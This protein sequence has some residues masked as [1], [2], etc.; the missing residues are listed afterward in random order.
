[1]MQYA[2]CRKQ[3]KIFTIQ[4]IVCS[5]HRAVCSEKIFRCSEQYALYHGLDSFTEVTFL[6]VDHAQMSTFVIEVCLSVQL[7]TSLLRLIENTDCG[8]MSVSHTPNQALLRTLVML[9]SGL[10]PSFNITQC[11]QLG[12]VWGMGQ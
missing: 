3:Y 10:R 8:I 2:L 5:L 9:S 7:V 1:M 11:S 12:L 4:F 6:N